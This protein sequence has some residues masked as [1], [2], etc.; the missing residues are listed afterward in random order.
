MKQFTLAILATLCM[1]IT[2]STSSHAQE[3]DE[4][5]MVANIGIGVGGYGALGFGSPGFSASLERGI[6][7]TGDFGVIGAGAYVGFRSG[8]YGAFGFTTDWKRTT[9]VVAPRATYHF[10]VIDVDQLDVYAAVQVDIA[11]GKDTHPSISDNTF[12]DIHPT[13]VA[14]A[15][16][17]FSENFAGFVEL[18]ANSLT[19][20]T[21][22]AS[23]RF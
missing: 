8:K 9:F 20:L 11:F 7:A 6:K 4:G 1:W 12:T 17:Y 10:T 22:G 2:N 23:L 14:A 15:R 19:Y 5:T 16:Y 3:Y 13:V 21:V 18:G